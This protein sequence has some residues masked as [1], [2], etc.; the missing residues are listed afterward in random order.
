VQLDFDDRVRK[1]PAGAATV[2]VSPVSTTDVERC[3]TC[4]DDACRRAGDLHSPTD[5]RGDRHRSPFS[6]MADECVSRV[7]TSARE[8]S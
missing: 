1:S 7:V 2:T 6:E 4:A 3:G 5:P 8:M